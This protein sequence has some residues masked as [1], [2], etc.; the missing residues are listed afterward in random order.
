MLY[1]I[2]QVVIIVMF[3]HVLRCLT[4]IH[5]C[6]LKFHLD[7]SPHI[8]FTFCS[9]HPTGATITY[10]SLFSNFTPQVPLSHTVHF[11]LTLLLH[12]IN[13]MWFIL[14]KIGCDSDGRNSAYLITLN[15][16]V[17]EINQHWAKMVNFYAISPYKKKAHIIQA[18]YSIC[19]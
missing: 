9:L 15:E 6:S 19:W 13:L 12:F 14:T 17:P 7:P 5:I 1:I 2:M 18:L 3:V 16:P 8:Q 10:S 4:Y 11:F